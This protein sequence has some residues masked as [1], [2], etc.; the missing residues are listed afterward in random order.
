MLRS[1]VGSEM[2][3]RDSI[4]AGVAA[5]FVGF[6]TRANLTEDKQSFDA[7]RE[8]LLTKLESYELRLIEIVR[9]RK[10]LIEEIPF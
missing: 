7:I 4:A 3:I 5:L 6:S 8:S 2:C 1:L 10:A 9:E